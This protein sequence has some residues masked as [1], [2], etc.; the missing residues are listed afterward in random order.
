[1]QV[2]IFQFNCE[3]IASFHG[4]Q[5]ASRKLNAKVVGINIQVQVVQEQNLRPGNPRCYKCSA[6]VRI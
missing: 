4:N 1:M 6:I 3:N 5:C 2:Q